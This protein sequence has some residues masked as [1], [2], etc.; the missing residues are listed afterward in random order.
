MNDVQGPPTNLSLIAPLQRGWDHMV[1]MLFRP[2]DLGKWFV[3]GFA[4]WLAGLGG[5]SKG[6]SSWSTDSEV[7]PVASAQ[8]GWEWL[9]AHGVVA[10]LIALAVVAILVLAVLVLWVSSRG[11]LIFLDNVVHNRSGIVE[12]WKRFRRLGN[13]LFAF[14]I[15]VFLICFPLFLGALGSVGW[16][17][18]RPGGWAHTGGPVPWIGLLITMAVA[19]PAFIALLYVRFFLDAFVV[20]L[21]HRYDLTVLDAWRRFLISF[22]RRPGWFL[23]SGLFVF[24]LFLIAGVLI[25]T[26][27][28]M[29]CCLGFMLLVVPYIGTVVLLPLIVTY[30]AFTVEFLAQ[31][32]PELRLT[33]R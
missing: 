7:D 4:A 32:E 6:G 2:F 12:P 11:K 15:A 17:A 8:Q 30:R 14:R 20:P 28:L 10:L 26:T 16:L 19:L 33:T 23:L 24:L 13:S 21:M 5:G 1:Q 22:R 18:F 27:G 31:L 9:A 25:I 29:T 3:V